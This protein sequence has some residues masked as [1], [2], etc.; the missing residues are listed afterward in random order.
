MPDGSYGWYYNGNIDDISIYSNAVSSEEVYDLY[1]ESQCYNPIYDTITTEVFDTTFVTIQDTIITEVY[2]TTYVTIIDTI[3][4]EMDT[5]FIT[6]HDTITTEVFD[7]IFVTETIIETITVTDTLIIDA[8]L[9]V[10]I[11]LITSILSK[12]IPTLLRKSYSSIQ[13]IMLK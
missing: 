6:I 8:V 7:T 11:L 5:T 9:P 2:D 12:S 10:L 4:A 1:S 3:I 13:V